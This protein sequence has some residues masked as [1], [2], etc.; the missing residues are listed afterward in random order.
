MPIPALMAIGPVAD[1]LN[2]VLNR[3]LPAEK[4]SEVDRAKLELELFKADWQSVIGQLEINKVEAAHESTFVS[5]W[6][7]FVGWVCG[8]G[9]AWA[10]VVQ[11]VVVLAVSLSQG[12]PPQ[13]PE[14]DVSLLTTT[15]FG[16]LGIA[17]MRTF[18]KLNGVAG[19]VTKES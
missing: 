19:R 12:E 1:L 5:G 17:G 3:V 16:M 18:E 14:L 4:M 9:F 8:C 11:P 13:L 7:P 2:N 6:R 15:L 10:A